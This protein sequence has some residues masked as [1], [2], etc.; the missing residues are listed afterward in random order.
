MSNAMMNVVPNLLATWIVL[1]GLSVIV[2]CLIVAMTRMCNY[3]TQPLVLY[4]PIYNFYLID[5][6]MFVTYLL[7]QVF[8]YWTI[9]LFLFRPFVPFCHLRS[10]SNHYVAKGAVLLSV[11]SCYNGPFFSYNNLSD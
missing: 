4:Y 11:L 6:L 7:C 3:F 8:K 2:I 9:I 5:N 10:F 1:L